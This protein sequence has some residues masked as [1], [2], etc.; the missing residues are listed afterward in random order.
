MIATAFITLKRGYTLKKFR[1]LFTFSLFL[2]AYHTN[3]FSS[4][5]AVL[6]GPHLVGQAE[7]HFKAT[8]DPD[9]LIDSETEIWGKL[10]YP[11]DSATTAISS[12]A[13]LIVMLHGNHATC[14][15]S[16]HPRIDDNCEYTTSGTCPTGYVP[17]PNHAGYDYL[18]KNLASWGYWVTSINAN[19]GIN[20]GA[21]QHNDWGLNL[22][23]GRL[24]LKHLSLFY[25]WSTEGGAPSSLGLGPQGLVG[26]IDIGN[27]GLMG[28]SRG[29]EGARAAYNLYSDKDNTWS[30]NIPGL[31]IKAIFEIGAVDG[32][33]DRVLDANGIA[34][35]Q[36]I[37]MCDGD[38]LDLEGRLPFE[39]MLL[40]KNEPVHAQKSLFEVWGANHNFFNTEWQSSD[41]IKCYTSKRIFKPSASHSLQ[42]QKIALASVTA[43][44]RS[45]LGSDADLTHS[46][47]FNPLSPLSKE[48]TSITQIDRDFTPTPAATEV[49]IVDDFDKD[50]LT[51][52]RGYPNSKND[53]TINNQFLENGHIQ[54]AAFIEWEKASLDTFFEAVMAPESHGRNLTD[55]STLDFRI[56]RKESRLND[57][58]TTN[59]T[60]VLVDAYNRWSNKVEVNKYSVING[61]GNY[62]PILKTVRI[63]LT[64]FKG[65]DLTKIHGVRFIFNKTKTGTIYLTNIRIHKQRGVGVTENTIWSQPSISDATAT[66]TNV[67]PTFVPANVNTIKR[68]NI[69]HNRLASENVVEVHVASQVPFPVM[70]RLPILKI[71]NKEFKLSRYADTGRLNELIFTLPLAEYQT[72]PRDGDVS[73][74]DGKIWQF[75][76]LSK[77]SGRN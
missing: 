51:S 23:R 4:A 41:S 55:F 14:G 58:S 46:K 76:T 65:I 74:S 56:A 6:P 10:F 62:I 39:R 26:K 9:I 35:N 40:N 73:V 22:A 66:V 42:Q 48:V 18:A 32:Q 57:S 25:K 72:L 13:P 50:T 69:V 60:I 8:L 1:I 19:R 75:G 17:V 77:W 16:S 70:N 28:H 49:E 29:G 11:K 33:T 24:I 36:L 63:P 43:F 3:A 30:A 12:K 2:I 52:T 61:P 53:I 27:V 7:Y 5:D 44:F 31:A 67:I 47:I 54:R 37:P 45:Q 38:V 59:F 68:I 71:A 64:E 20:C 15:R 21:G 34:W